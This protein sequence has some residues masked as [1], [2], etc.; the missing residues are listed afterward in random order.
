MLS[1]P[2]RRSLPLT[3]A[4]DHFVDSTDV[5]NKPGTFPHVASPFDV[6]VEAGT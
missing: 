1:C 6:W 4:I 3:G 5:A 2:W